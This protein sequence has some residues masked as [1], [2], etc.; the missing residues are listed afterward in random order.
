MLGLLRVRSLNW[1]SATTYSVALMATGVTLAADP[2]PP[3]AP[4]ATPPGVA[5]PFIPPP[6]GI[7]PPFVPQ[8]ISP[9]LIDFVTGMPVSHRM[10]VMATPRLLRPGF[11]GESLAS[12]KGLASQI[13]AKEL[14]VPKRVKAAKYL[15]KVDCQAFPDS[16]Q[17]LL[18][19]IEEDE[20]EEVRLAAAKAFKC[21]FSRGCD[22][23]PSKKKQRRY[24]TCRGCCNNVDVLNRLAARAYECDETGCAKEPSPR[25]REAIAEA[26][27]CCCCFNYLG[28]AEHWTQPADM[29]VPPTPADNTPLQPTPEVKEKPPVAPP[30]SASAESAGKSDVSTVGLSQ[31]E[32]VSKELQPVGLEEERSE[33]KGESEVSDLPLVEC[34]RGNCPVAMAERRLEKAMPEIH[35]IHNGHKYEFATEEAKAA[36]LKDPERYAPVLSG[37]CVVTFAKTGEKVVGKFCREH[38]GQQYWFA[39]KEV[40]E[41]FKAAP[42]QFI[43]MLDDATEE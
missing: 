39:S 13:K 43:E 5:P 2:P 37:H 22:P 24:D 6:A 7:A 8:P 11:A 18:A 42:D 12:A 32:S 21:Q 38:N 33:A 26:L 20:F 28:G 9:T 14:D 3:A 17:K 29:S 31:D 23:D 27:N 1:F 4:V 15:G 36:F 30:E 19:L 41:E 10:Q 34:L 16:Q 40:R 35:A 25:V